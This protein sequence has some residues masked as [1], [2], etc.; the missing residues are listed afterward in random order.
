[1]S[2]DLSQF[3]TDESGKWLEVVHPVTGAPLTDEDGN[4]TAILLVGKDSKEYRQA[5]R[6][7]TARRLK[8]N[9]KA[10]PDLLENEVMEVW[11]ACTKDWRGIEED[12][13]E[14]ECTPAN[15]R[16]VYAKYRFVAEQVEEFIEDRGNFIA[17]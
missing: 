3:E 1:M 8:P 13:V 4:T 6:K 7:I 9:R 5:Q 16:K 15:V 2:I 14:L 17:T 12:G 11:T 10:T